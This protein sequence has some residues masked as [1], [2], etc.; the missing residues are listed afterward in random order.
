MPLVGHLNSLV[1]HPGMRNHVNSRVSP[2]PAYLLVNVAEVAVPHFAVARLS[3][4]VRF[5][6]LTRP[7][8]LFTSPDSPMRYGLR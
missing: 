4:L 6:S 2:H 1:E 7:T 3:E 5:R 8:S